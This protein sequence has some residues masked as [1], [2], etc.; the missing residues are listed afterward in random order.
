MVIGRGPVIVGRMVIGRGPAIVA[1]TETG[2]E[3]ATA[4]RTETGRG[5]VIVRRTVIGPE[6][7]TGTADGAEARP[8]SSTQVSG[9]LGPEPQVSAR[10]GQAFATATVTGIALA[11]GAVIVRVSA[12]GTTGR[13]GGIDGI[14]TSVAPVKDLRP[15]AGRTVVGCAIETATVVEASIDRAMADTA[16]L[17]TRTETVEAPRVAGTAMAP[18][19]RFGKDAASVSACRRTSLCRAR[20]SSATRRAH[21]ASPTVRCCRPISTRAASTARCA[22]SCG[23]WP[24]ESPNRYRYASWPPGS[25]STRSPRR[26]SRI[27]WS[28]AGWL[29]AF[30]RYGRRWA[31][32]PTAPASGRQQSESCGRTTG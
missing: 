28:R 7:A 15:A 9:V 6:R 26:R 2:P 30:R 18:G 5:R 10:T 20:L 23:L 4:H 1:R 19:P 27:R 29:R 11:R 8:A 31:L 14:G 21:R 32:L 24:A 3:P 22:S 13:I 25:S 16:V 17:A 12:I